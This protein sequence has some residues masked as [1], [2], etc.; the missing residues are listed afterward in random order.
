[1]CFWANFWDKIGEKQPILPPKT[2]FWGENNA[3][4]LFLGDFWGI[5]GKRRKEKENETKEFQRRKMHKK[6]TKEV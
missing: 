6:K 3:K 1:M 4:K 2:L 5:F